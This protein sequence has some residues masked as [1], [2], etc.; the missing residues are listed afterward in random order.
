MTHILVAGA[1]HP[2]GIALLES[3][4]DVT[5]DYVQEVSESS[6]APLIWRADALVLR[7]QPLSETTIAAATRLRVVSRHG[8]GYDAVDVASLEARGIGLTVLG[9]VNTVSVAEHAMMM[10]LAVAKRT[11]PA[12]RA[13]RDGT[14]AWRNRLEARELAGKRLLILGYGRIGRSL[15]GMALAFGMLV[16]AY[17]PYLER[18]GWPAGEVAPMADLAEGLGWADAVSVNIPR[19]GRPILGAAELA[20]LRPGAILVNTARGGVVDE[21]ALTEALESGHL[22]GAGLDV[23]DDEPPDANN[24]LLAL[25]NVVLSPH[26]AGLTRECSERMA[27]ESVNNVLTFLAGTI[28]PGLIVRTHRS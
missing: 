20:S 1:L 26:I 10:L 18:Q 24:R 5:Y 12:D 7:T 4:P 6:Y 22:A 2:A 25:D 19:A 9:D 23:F 17:D 21:R 28:D 14:W 11:V 8:V 16:R 15:A 27:V 3:T 13:V